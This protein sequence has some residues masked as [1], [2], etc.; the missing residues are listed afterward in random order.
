MKSDLRNLQGMIKLAKTSFLE[1]KILEASRRKTSLFKLVDSLLLVKPGLCLPAHDSLTALVEHLSFFWVSKI[2]AIR[3]TLDAVTSRGRR[4]PSD[5][6][7]PNQRS[8]Q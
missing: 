8:Q 5:L 3:A 7:L 2:A 6:L 1:A 4:R